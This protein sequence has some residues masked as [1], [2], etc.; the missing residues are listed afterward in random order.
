MIYFLLLFNEMLCLFGQLN[1]LFNNLFG[2]IF[3]NFIQYICDLFIYI[4]CDINLTI[5]LTYWRIENLFQHFFHIKLT[6]VS[7]RQVIFMLRGINWFDLCLG[8]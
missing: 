6:I 4:L 2:L 3:F 1:K 5:Y 8:D 7:H